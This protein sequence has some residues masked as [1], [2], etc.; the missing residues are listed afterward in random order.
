MKWDD[1]IGRRLRLKDLH[2][3]QTVAESGSMAKAA[4][5]L[6]LSQPAISKAI[7]EMEG[8]LGA[9]LLN[10]GAR[11]VELTECGQLLVE[12][13]RVIFDEMR[14]GVSDIQSLSD[15]AQGLIK[16]GTTEA[17]TVVV[18][19][20][21]T[22]LTRKYPR[23]SFDVTVSDGPS[24]VRQLQRRELDVV[25]TRW[26]STGDNEGLAIEAL[27]KSPLAVM[28]GRRHRLARKSVNL[29]DLMEEQWTL[30]PPDALFGRLVTDL[31]RRRKLE[32]PRNVVATLSTTMKLSLLA[33]GKFLSILPVAMLRHPLSSAWLRALNIDLSETADP[34]TSITLKRRQSGGAI[35]LFQEM[36]RSVCRG[37]AVAG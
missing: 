20:I 3:L 33:D 36:S 21:I 10:R 27:F 13:S 4:E 29:A 14:Q 19:Q 11:G 2:T 12:R 25:L 34:I 16:I 31:F 9:S 8:V 1:R 7:A 24:L 28:V 23:I 6:A 5:Q 37:I 30:S 35:R 18:S 22:Q 32:P 17:L 15:P 26:L